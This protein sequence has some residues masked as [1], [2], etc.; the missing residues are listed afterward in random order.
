MKMKLLKL[1]IID[2]TRDNIITNFN[3]ISNTVLSPEELAEFM[4]LVNDFEFTDDDQLCSSLRLLKNVL[5]EQLSIMDLHF[6]YTVH[7]KGFDDAKKDF[8]ERCT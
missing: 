6:T 7:S 5:T 2:G 1:Y 3:L 4:T 8:F